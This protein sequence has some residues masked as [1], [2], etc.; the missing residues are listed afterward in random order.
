M[1]LGSLGMQMQRPAVYVK[2]KGRQEESSFSQH[3]DCTPIVLMKIVIITVAHHTSVA[4]LG[5]GWFN[6]H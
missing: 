2:Y 4:M 3:T 5:F 6:L 1:I